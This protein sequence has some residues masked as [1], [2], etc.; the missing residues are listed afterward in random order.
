M[1]RGTL[2]ADRVVH[3]YGDVVAL[4][5]VS[6][7]VDAGECLALVGESGSGKTTLLRCFN[8][9]V[10]PGEGTVRVDGRD[11]MELNPIELRRSIGYVQQEGGLLPHWT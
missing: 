1:S 6:V 4:D 11:V 2:E 3:R 10:E 8:R 7:R 9:M 5:G